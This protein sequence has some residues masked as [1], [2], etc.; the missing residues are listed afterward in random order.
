MNGLGQHEWRSETHPVQQIHKLR[1]ERDE[2]QKKLSF[3]NSLAINTTY[4]VGR[5]EQLITVLSV[6]RGD[7]DLC[8]CVGDWSE[9]HKHVT[10]AVAR[11]DKVLGSK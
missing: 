3:L 6:A 7:L 9:L 2:L 11:I 10:K 8:K 1:E 5:N 4:L